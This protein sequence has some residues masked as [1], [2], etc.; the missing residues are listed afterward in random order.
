MEGDGPP[1]SEFS[2]AELGGLAGATLGDGALLCV[3]NSVEALG[4]ASLAAL[5]ML[6]TGGGGGGMAREARLA[7]VGTLKAAK[8]VCTIALTSD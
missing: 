8:S 5:E 3:V 7:R 4:C 2:E 6:P 1:E